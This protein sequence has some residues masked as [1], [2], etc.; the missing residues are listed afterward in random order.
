MRRRLT[1]IERVDASYFLFIAPIL[2]L[3]TVF[4][5][6]PA[7]RGLT[8]SFTNF[9]GLSPDYSFVG[10]RNYA[11]L[12]NDRSYWGS[13]A[14][15]VVFTLM[16]MVGANLIALVVAGLLST[17]TSLNGVSRVLFFL[18]HVL[19]FVIVGTVW[20]FILGR[21]ATQLSETLGAGFMQP[22]WISDPGLALPSAAGVAIWHATGWFVFIYLA[23]YQA[24]PSD[25]LE[26]AE[27]DGSVGLHRFVHVKLPFLWP[28]IS[29]G[30][31]LALTRAM[32]EFGLIFN[33]TG[34]GP[35]NATQTV[36]IN[37]YQSS[38]ASTRYGYGL[39]KSMTLVLVLVILGLVQR[40]LTSRKVQR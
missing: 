18:P 30:L 6:F 33:L 16:F 34:G 4:F 7:A 15:T 38:F 12:L 22:G 31:F 26:A 21:L 13:Y 39:S 8:L 29:V 24:I 11:R 28:T 1:S 23:A 32:K 20:F 36:L 10:L 37:I 40:H 14:N 17:P 9:N 2:L 25:V 19:N 3:Y 5:I 27:M 35:G